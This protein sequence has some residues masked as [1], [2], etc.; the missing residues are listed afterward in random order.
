MIGS[1]GC[2]PLM[3]SAVLCALV[4][5]VVLAVPL[6]LQAGG[7]GMSN[8]VPVLIPTYVG[9]SQKV[10]GKVTAQA[11]A[12]AQVAGEFQLVGGQGRAS[13]QTEVRVCYD[14]DALYIRFECFEDRMASLVMNHREDDQPVWQD[15]SVEFY[16]SPHSVPA[17]SRSH[18][19][20]VNAAGAK[21][22]LRPDWAGAAHNWRAAVARLPDRWVADIAIPYDTLRPLGKNDDCWRVNFCR[23]E[24]PHGETSSWSAVDR[25]FL[26]CARFGRLIPPPAPFRFNTFRGKPVVLKPDASAPV[27]LEAVTGDVKETAANAVIIPEPQEL[28]HRPSKPPFRISGDTRIVVGDSA[29]QADMW[30]VEELVAAIER[31]GG[32][33]L[34]V[35]RSSELGPEPV[36]SRGL[37]LIGEPANHGVLRAFCDRDSVRMP[38]SRFGTTSHVV[39][40]TEGRVIAAGQTRV[41][42]YYAVQTLKQLLTAGAGG[43]VEVPAVEVRDYPR[44][45]FRGVHLLT[46]SDALTYISKLIDRVLAPMKVNHIVLQTDK[47]AWKSHPEVTDPKNSMPREDVRKLIEVA[48]RHHIAVTPLVQSPGHLEWAFRD[49]K[50]LEFAEDPNLPYCYC[51]S[52]PKSY[53]FIFDIMDEAIELF[54]NPGY[55][56]AG[57]DEFDMRGMM[58][59]DDECKLVGKEQLYIRDTLKIYEHLRSRGCGM[60]MWGDILLKAG[61]RELAGQLPKDILINDWHYAA[62][63]TYPSLDFFQSL[64]FPVIG[65]TWY[66]ARNISTFSLYAARRSIG[67]MMQTTWT[68]FEPAEQVLAKYPA[69]VYAYILSAAWAWN[70]VKPEV[71]AL[72]YRPEAVFRRLWQDSPEVADRRLA[73]VSIDRFCNV[74]RSDS[75]RSVGWLGLG[76]DNDLRELPSGLVRIGGVPYKILGGGLEEPSVVLLGAE[77]MLADLPRRVNS[78]PIDARVKGLHFLDGCAFAV[79][80]GEWVGSYIIH[81]ED[82]TKEEIRLVYEQNVYAWDDQS[83]GVAYGFA[84]RGRARDGHAVGVCDLAWV[85][86]RPEVKVSSIDFVASPSQAS[87]FLLAVTAELSTASRPSQASPLPGAP[88]AIADP[89]P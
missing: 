53:E 21:A 56:H 46:S 26:T 67:G 84:W 25:R 30:A 20:V 87:P 52:N 75:G 47:I 32:P 61:F 16:V 65:C 10:N 81:Y 23:N 78:I 1:G 6:S 49:K 69:Q 12:G 85:N 73:T 24:H 41:D 50:N 63:D 22:L 42:T 8:D 28:H 5:A 19:F 18:Q 60:M 34:P 57:R 45:Q 76:R 68:G 66:N 43:A 86:K 70:P 59:Y 62:S 36:S 17:K 88:A 3:R 89:A 40:V 64:G 54:G 33:R 38:R 83:L 51:M 15:D 58:P 80:S 14:R 72:P 2:G 9:V 79:D 71:S 37:I 4:L 48:R 39:D 55:F 31:V 29:D 77:G 44:F 7:D 11:W 35:V 74:S 27:G 82:G 13:Q